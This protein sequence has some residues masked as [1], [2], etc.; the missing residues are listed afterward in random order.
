MPATP[1]AAPTKYFAVGT[2]ILVFATS[3]SVLTA[4][5]RAEINAGTDL[6]RAIVEVDGWSVGSNLMDAPNLA[7]KFNAKVGGRT[8][9]DASSIT[10]YASLTT[11]DVRTLMPRDTAGFILVMW[12]GDVAGRRMDAFPVTVAS[13]GKTIPDNRASDIKVNFAITAQP[14]EDVVIP[15]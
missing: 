1:I 9:A 5:S 12:A 3:V 6:T 7:D 11:S 4:P 10:F 15:A 2:T 8:E 14:A 13:V